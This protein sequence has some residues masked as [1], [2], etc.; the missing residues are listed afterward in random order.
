MFEESWYLR[1]VKTRGKLEQAGVNLAPLQRVIA[2]H[3]LRV[4]LEALKH[5]KIPYVPLIPPAYKLAK[6]PDNSSFVTD[7]TYWQ[8]GWRSSPP[9]KN[10]EETADELEQIQEWLCESDPESSLDY[11]LP[12]PDYICDRGSQAPTDNVVMAAPATAAAATKLE[13]PYSPP[14]KMLTTQ[15]MTTCTDVWGETYRV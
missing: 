12:V 10:L 14:T 4:V 8:V 6:W 13:V 3:G 2:E 9:Y 1:A 5:R 15:T 7:P 11:S